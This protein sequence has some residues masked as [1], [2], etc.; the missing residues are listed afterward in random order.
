MTQTFFTTRSRRRTLI[1]GARLVLSTSMAVLCLAA[2]PTLAQPDHW[3]SRPIRMIVPFAAGSFTDGVARI[4][5]DGL[6]KSLGQ[7]VVVENRTGANGLI[8]MQEAS[9]AKGDGYTLLVTN[10]SSITIN[11]HIYKKALYKGTDFSPVT[12][13]IEAPFIL[14]TNP[15]W[16]KKNSVN[17]VRDLVQYAKRNPGKLNY[18]SAGIGN[19]AHLSFALLSSS[20]QI[21]ANHVPYKTA[22][23]SQLA[24]MGGELDA[25][26]DS[27]TALP[28]IAAGKLKALG[29]TSSRRMAQLPDT[30]TMEQAGYPQVNVTFWVGL[31]AP[32][33]TPKE[34]VDKLA[35]SSKAML[36]DPRLKAALSA[37]GEPIMLNQTSF[38]KRIQQETAMWETVVQ[39]EKVSID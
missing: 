31:L 37:Q 1:K 33:G 38:A 7:P 17:S 16:A 24:V 21:E 32:S 20:A 30:A 11:P 15:E 29:V 22:P 10:S 23:A 14:V 12:M 8:G 36:D 19:M 25:H 39:R 2:M 28:Q 26:F 3:P 13:I 6:S 5:S 9:R 18:G 34:I 4:M 27:W 35:A